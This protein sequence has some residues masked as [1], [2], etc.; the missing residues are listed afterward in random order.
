M[1]EGRWLDK[2]T[3]AVV[4]AARLA[5]EGAFRNVRS[6]SNQQKLEGGEAGELGWSNEDGLVFGKFI[7]IDGIY[8]PASVFDQDRSGNWGLYE[9]CPARQLGLWYSAGEQRFLLGGRKLRESNEN[10]GQPTEETY[11]FGLFFT[12]DGKLV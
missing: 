2:D 7:L 5:F 3:V 12:G 10:P 11:E 8:L 4:M 6:V 1:L 9:S